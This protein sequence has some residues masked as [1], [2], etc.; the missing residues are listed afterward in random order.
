VFLFVPDG[1]GAGDVRDTVVRLPIARDDGVGGI[2]RP[3][4]WNL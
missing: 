4:Y 2:P 3:I 1:V